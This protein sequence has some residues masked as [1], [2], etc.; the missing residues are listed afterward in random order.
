MSL[1][2]FEINTI[3]FNE[4]SKQEPDLYFIKRIDTN[5][6]LDQVGNDDIDPKTGIFLRLFDIEKADTIIPHYD[7]QAL[8]YIISY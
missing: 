1:L 2:D 7:Y 5:K 8:Y 3:I 6:L 4:D